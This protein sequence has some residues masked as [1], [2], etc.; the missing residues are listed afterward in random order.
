MYLIQTLNNL[1]HTVRKFSFNIH[2]II[3]VPALFITACTNQL[4]TNPIHV[5]THEVPTHSEATD[6]Q[7]TTEPVTT[8]ITPAMPPDAS[9]QD[10]QPQKRIQVGNGQYIAPPQRQSKPVSETEKDGTILNFQGTDINEFIKAILGDIL[11][12]NFIID[13]QISG[14]VTIETS[15]PIDPKEIFPLFEK[16]LAMNN[17]VIV[18]SDGFYQILPRSKAIQGV[19]SP[20]VS[21]H[22]SKTLTPGYSL[23]IVPLQYI[24]AEEIQKILLPIIKQ[25]NNITIDKRRNMLLL[26]GTAQELNTLQE[27]INIFDVDWLRGMSIGLYPLEYVDPK[28]VQAELGNI[29]GGTGGGQGLLDGLVKTVVIERLNAILLMSS[30]LSAL[31]TTETWLQRLD[32]PGESVGQHLHVYKVQNAKATEL[33]TIL[34]D[35]FN[36]QSTT[37]TM[38]QNVGLVPGETAVTI[39]DRNTPIEEAAPPPPSSTITTDPEA[40]ALLI[41]DA[42]KIIADDTRNA[43]VILATP[44]DY[45][46]I[47]SAIKK[48][49]IVPLQVLIEASI[50]EVNLEDEL[51]YGVEWFFKNNIASNAAQGRLDLGESGLSTLTGFSYSVINNQNNIS[52][53]LNALQ[54]ES[55]VK[56]LSSPSLM[57]LDNQTATINVGDEIPVPTRQSISTIVGT[58]APTVNEIQYRNTG[59]TLTVTPRVNDSGLVTM[60]LSQEVSNAVET[61][62]SE[63]NAPT[64]Q[65]RLIKSTVAINSGETIVLGGLIRETDTDNES[66]IPILYKIPFL[67][68]LFGQTANKT[69]RTELI[70]LLTPHVIRNYQ[71]ARNITDEFRNKLRAL[72]VFETK[73]QA[74]AKQE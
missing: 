53:I 32:R 68:R 12:Q 6:T 65:Q 63:I 29:L 16:I 42:I 55:D 49:D 69:R 18:K 26:V 35:I 48:L 25:S 45:K 58:D 38:K 9:H 1:P 56:V 66:G 74:G 39:S 67:G 64:I 10:Q 15:R 24:A 14:T 51:S 20:T 19:F 34:G 23:R 28:T 61:E 8:I 3:F 73:S 17:I 50:L 54:S 27:T 40:P 2:A 60:E 4:A 33:A 46:M 71:D 13:P 43:L 52:F 36:S 62:S 31:H 70:V 11:N 7:A 30:T 37:S 72:S 47:V 5:P 59:V 22:T 57:V 44:R 21:T 41:T